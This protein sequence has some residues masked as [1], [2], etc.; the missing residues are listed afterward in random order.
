MINIKV[1]KQDDF[2]T[3]VT[4][5]GHAGYDELGKD[6]VCASV[7]SISITTVNACTRLENEKIQ[8]EEKDGFLDIKVKENSRVINILMNN[9][10]D[11]FKN[12]EEDYPNYI[13]IT[14]K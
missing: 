5:K 11:L 12:L 9:M 10:I 14:F 2:I 4:I 13:K 8:Y 1:S 3:R 6:I 7:S